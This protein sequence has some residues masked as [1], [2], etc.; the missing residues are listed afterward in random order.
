MSDTSLPPAIQPDNQPPI[1]TQDER[2]MG[3]LCHLL[4]ILTGFVGPLILWLVKKDESAF[5]DHHGK[6]ALNFQI[7]YI[8]V[9]LGASAVI[10]VLCFL[11]IGFFL[12]PVLFVLP[13]LVI[14]AGIIACISANNGEWSRYPGCI[15]LIA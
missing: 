7:T 9:A 5:I 13:I 15:R 8:L 12:L 1:P 6:E 11:V 4:G 10:F 2:T 14:I 3:M